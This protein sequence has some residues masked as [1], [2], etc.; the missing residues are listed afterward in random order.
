MYVY[1][2]ALSGINLYCMSYMSSASKITKVSSLFAILMATLWLKL[3]NVFAP[4]V[5]RIDCTVTTFKLT[6]I[7][8]SE[9]NSKII[10][11][12]SSL[13]NDAKGSVNLS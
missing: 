7:L 4:K 2:V 10:G 3:L 8:L 1:I 13:A 12:S 6:R 11:N 5:P 9:G